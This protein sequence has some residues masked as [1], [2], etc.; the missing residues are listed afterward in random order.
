MSAVAREIQE[1]TCY[2]SM[3]RVEEDVLCECNPFGSDGAC[4]K[5]EENIAIHLG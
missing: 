4:L 1:Y 5:V 2:F 3:A